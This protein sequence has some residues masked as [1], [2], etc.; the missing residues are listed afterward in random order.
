MARDV[1][2]AHQRGLTEP[3]AGPDTTKALRAALMRYGWA[4][5]LVAIATALGVAYHRERTFQVVSFARL[6]TPCSLVN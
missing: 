3:P 1:S 4:A 5:T 2:R 6:T